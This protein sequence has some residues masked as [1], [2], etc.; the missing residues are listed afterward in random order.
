MSV[1][2]LLLLLHLHRSY[3]IVCLAK[4]SFEISRTE[5]SSTNDSFALQKL[6][7][8]TRH[9]SVKASVCH[10]TI[11]I[12]YH[13]TDGGVI[14]GF[15]QNTNR[16]RDYFGFESRLPLVKANDSIV[17]YIDYVCSWDDLC[18]Q[19]FVDKWIYWL[20][21]I[22]YESLQDKLIDL[23][24][25]DVQLNRCYTADRLTECSSGMCL[26]GHHSILS[27]IDF[28]TY[29]IGN[30]SSI[31]SVLYVKMQSIEFKPMEYDGLVYICT[32]DEC[33]G[34][35][36]FNRVL[37]ETEHL[38]NVIEPIADWLRLSNRVKKL[39]DQWTQTVRKVTGY[40][41]NDDVT[42]HSYYSST[43]RSWWYGRSPLFLFVAA[44]L[45]C[46]AYCCK[47]SEED[48]TTPCSV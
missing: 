41:P 9:S 4:S 36:T 12:D 3:S 44:F 25:S 28:D 29:C 7:N 1:I 11:S 8:K 46:C 2:L 20:L 22:K 26:A 40:Q 42:T 32:S 45:F 43:T 39:F 15:G 24:T 37:K 48:S 5:L 30:T 19:R 23:L 18:D 13:Q 47:E 31:N 17:I 27:N 10:V 33:N 34:K 38:I 6:I 21:N 16:T 35:L 14:I